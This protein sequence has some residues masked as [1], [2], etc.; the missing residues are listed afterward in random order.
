MRKTL[1]REF[2]KAKVSAWLKNI[3]SHL[4]R[5]GFMQEQEVKELKIS[6][7]L[8]QAGLESSS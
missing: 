8:R 6:Y 7:E 5:F 3:A 4:N 1:E 2:K